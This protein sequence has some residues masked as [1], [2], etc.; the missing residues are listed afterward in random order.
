MT[1]GYF[2][3]KT[4]GPD[5]AP[6]SKSPAEGPKLSSF[7]KPKARQIK[8]AGM[9]ALPDGCPLCNAPPCQ[10]MRIRCRKQFL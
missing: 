6:S 3:L 7:K 2:H 8:K 9:T 10:T 1:T 5:G 4:D